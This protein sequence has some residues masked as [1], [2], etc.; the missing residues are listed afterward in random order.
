LDEATAI[1]GPTWFVSNYQAKDLASYGFDH[2]LGL[3]KI[4]IV[5]F[6]RYLV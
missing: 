2:Y 4:V 3:K 1:T 6:F 5:D